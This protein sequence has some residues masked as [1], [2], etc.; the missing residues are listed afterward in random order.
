MLQAGVR[1][2]DRAFKAVAATFIRNLT[3]PRSMTSVFT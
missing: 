1:E 3:S 2:L